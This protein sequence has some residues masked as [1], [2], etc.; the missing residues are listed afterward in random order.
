MAVSDFLKEQSDDT[1]NT[2]KS[3]SLSYTPEWSFDTEQPDMG[4]A[5]GLAFADM[6]GDTLKRFY[7]LPSK[8][9]LQFYNLLGLEP[10]PTD[11]AAGYVTFSTVNEEVQGSW[12]KEG[13]RLIG[14]TE[15]GKPVIFETQEALYVSSA[16]LNRVYY[17]NGT[18]GCIS[19]PMEFPVKVQQEEKGQS[20]I[21]YIGHDV[22][23]GIKTEG[24]IVLDF[25]LSR[26]VRKK[27]QEEFLMN[28]ITWSYYSREGFVE[29]PEFCYEEGRVYLH[30]DTVMLPFERTAIQGRDSFWL[31][32]ETPDM[33]PL[34]RI[35]FPKLSLS[36]SGSFLAP[37]VVYDGNME[38][39]RESFL[40]FGEHPFPNGEVY[41]SLEE[42]FSKRG[43]MLE[44]SFGLDFLEYPGELKSPELPVK[45]HNIM[46]YSEFR[47]P[48]PV[49]IRID[50]VIW[51][52]YNGLGWTRIPDTGSYEAIFREKSGKQDISV[53]F[54]CPEDVAP[55]LLAARESYCIR[56]RITQMTNL[57]SMD[58]IYI[59]P[60]IKN[61]MVHYRCP[62][63]GMLPDFACCVNCLVTEKLECFH[64]F[65]PFY[66]FFPDNEMLYLSFSKPL[67]EEGIRLLF[68][69]RGDRENVHTR[70]HYEYYGKDGW[71]PLRVE[72]ET[73]QLSRTGLV[74]IY[75]EHSFARKEFFGCPGYWLRIVRERDGKEN[76]GRGFPVITG[77]YINSTAVAAGEGSGKSGNLPA[78][79]ITD[80]ERGIGF[81]NRVTNRE[82]MTGG[83]DGENREQAVRRMAA[84][85]RHWGRAVTAADFEDIVLHGVRN[86]LQVRCFSGRN[87]KGDRMPGHITLAVLPETEEGRCFEYVRERI[88]RCLLPHMDRR[89]YDEGRL[90]IVKPEWVS[91]KLY[92]AVVAKD[93]VRPFQLRE[94]L[95]QRINAFL[96]PVTG[97]FDGTGW[98]IG[99]LPSVLQIENL[100]S[101]M[102]EILYVKHISLKDESS[103]GCYVL[104]AGGEHEI[105]MIPEDEA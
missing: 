73:R 52:Y 85:L 45:W 104:A 86:L 94:K 11:E 87:E 53:K 22:L 83:C 42:A 30:K 51:E 98:R 82:A 75:R 100:C 59:V 25:H 80:M 95:I 2:I 55:F 26:N 105:E 16:R 33:S 88:Y 92:M 7:R 54:I 19:R 72:D 40:P 10:L 93:S 99:F 70:Y 48:E 69:V 60:R 103:E 76:Q 77:I 90:H 66:N 43:A 13:E 29:F 36:S 21:C 62:E 24:E 78:G 3:R 5:L 37:E 9:Q 17:V 96:D 84:F 44:L 14:K 32:M 58:G 20:H 97:N 38:M 57:Y 50:S 23:F 79:A 63:S 28:R 35:S 15:G 18:T 39:D 61:L 67:R 56:I 64:D 27:E 41:I 102:E 91:M 65:S 6:M 4:T 74:T 101:Q 68:V 46:H 1:V 71:K 31:R 12:V 8:Y 49:D 47:E 81:I 34:S 89:L